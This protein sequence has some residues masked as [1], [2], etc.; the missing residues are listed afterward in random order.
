K[1]A[2]SPQLL[3]HTA[4]DN[5]TRLKKPSDHSPKQQ[6]SLLA[7]ALTVVRPD[8][9]DHPAAPP[10]G[11]CKLIPTAFYS[12]PFPPCRRGVFLTTD[13]ADGH[14]SK[15]IRAHPFNPWSTSENISRLVSD[16]ALCSLCPSSGSA[17]WP[18]P[19]STRGGPACFPSVQKFCSAPLYYT[20]DSITSL[21]QTLVLHELPDETGPVRQH[22][23]DATLFGPKAP[24]WE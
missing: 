3:N 15:I 8:D 10:A 21:V 12:E 20:L 5:K 16:C 2:T 9:A 13:R 11:C 18:H 6:G 14:G 22:P 1:A 19:K 23:A 4:P 7:G 17:L 24:W